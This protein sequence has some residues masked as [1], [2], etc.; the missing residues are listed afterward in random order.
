MFAIND[1]PQFNSSL[2][3]QKNILTLKKY[4]NFGIAMDTDDGLVV[5]I[6]KDVDKK[7][8]FTLSNQLIEMNKK[9]K[10]KKLTPKDF[11]AGTFTISSLGSLGGDYFSPI[12]NP[13][14]VAIIGVSKAKIEPEYIDGKFSPCLMLPY[15]LS[16]DHRVIDGAEAVRFC[17]K[18]NAFLENK[19]LLNAEFEN[20]DAFK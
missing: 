12:I 19:E 6:I 16:Y 20:I 5:P 11:E 2:N 13:P 17:K 7:N 9:A 14:E 8:I 15:S 18:I 3:S 10:N 1:F 4:F